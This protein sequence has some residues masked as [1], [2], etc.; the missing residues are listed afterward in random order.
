MAIMKSHRH[1]PV[2]GHGGYCIEDI[3]TMCTS[4]EANIENATI[5]GTSKCRVLNPKVTSAVA[6]NILRPIRGCDAGA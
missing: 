2:S 3:R 4:V 5:D 6:H 1:V